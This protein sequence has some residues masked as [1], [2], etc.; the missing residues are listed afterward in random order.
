MIE[1]IKKK[2]EVFNME[3]EFIDINEEEMIDFIH[4]HLRSQGLACTKQEIIWI[5]NSQIEYYK[6]I[7]LME[8]DI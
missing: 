1:P 3:A 6:H 8:E 2:K 4:K 7:G 5:L